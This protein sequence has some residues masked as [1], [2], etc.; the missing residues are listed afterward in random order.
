MRSMSIRIRDYNGLLYFCY[1]TFPH[2]YFADEN[3]NLSYLTYCL[4]ELLFNSVLLHDLRSIT[5][6]VLSIILL[7]AICLYSYRLYEYIFK[8]IEHIIVLMRVGYEC[9][10][11]EETRFF[12]LLIYL[13]NFA[14]DLVTIQLLLC[15]DYLNV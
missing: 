6:C 14:L 13:V 10:F 1:V 3:N 15:F 2:W 9:E 11:T 4:F 7:L 5:K 8:C 12:A